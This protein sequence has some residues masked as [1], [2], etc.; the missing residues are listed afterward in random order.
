MKAKIINKYSASVI[1]YDVEINKINLAFK[2]EIVNNK[3]TDDVINRLKNKSDKT[4]DEL[5]AIKKREQLDNWRNNQINELNQYSDFDVTDKPNDLSDIDTVKPYYTQ[6]TSGKV[7]LKW[8]IIKNSIDKI[9]TKIDKLK[10]ELYQSD[11]KVIKC[12]EAVMS[13]S[14]EM[15]Y[16]IN[17][18]IAERQA[19]RDEINELRKLLNR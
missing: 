14:V 10:K 16:D 15:P 11:Y 1:D 8:E 2:Q 19:K 9:N 12:Y 6:E 17:A 5:Q 13:S 18:L 4:N 3:I 7:V